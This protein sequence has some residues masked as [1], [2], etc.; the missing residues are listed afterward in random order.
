MKIKPLTDGFIA[1]VKEWQLDF[2][3]LRQLIEDA[4]DPT[5]LVRRLEECEDALWNYYVDQQR[6][7]ADHADDDRARERAHLATSAWAACET[8]VR[9][10]ANDDVET[11]IFWSMRLGWCVAKLEDLTHE[12]AAQSWAKSLAGSEKGAKKQR[13]RFAPKLERAREA[14]I[15]EYVR[16]PSQTHTKVLTTVSKGLG[17]NRE[18]LRKRL[19]KGPLLQKAQERRSSRI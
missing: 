1:P 8:I 3:E 15:D 4:R 10:W 17:I 14:M 5:A 16:D 2:G 6:L 12:R 11:A 9:S 19:K 18:S 7:L 13:D